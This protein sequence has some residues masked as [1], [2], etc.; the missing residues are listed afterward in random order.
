MNYRDENSRFIL[1]HFDMYAIYVGSWKRKNRLQTCFMS[2][3]IDIC[4]IVGDITKV[5]PFEYV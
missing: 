3:C 1:L 2:V 5:F 4:Y